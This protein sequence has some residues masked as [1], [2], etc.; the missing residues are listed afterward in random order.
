M[1]CVFTRSTST[2]YC[3]MFERNDASTSWMAV[4]VLALAT[5][6][7]VTLCS[8]AMSKLPSRNCT[9][10][11]KPASLPTPWIG[12]GGMTRISASGMALS[13]AFRPVN[14]ARRSSPLPRSLQ[15]FRMM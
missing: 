5:I 2:E 12:G 15:S 4:W 9:C 13:D 8:L 7:L 11:V 6:A 10:M 1:A 3:G 14:S